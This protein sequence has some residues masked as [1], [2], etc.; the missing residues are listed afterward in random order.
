MQFRYLTVAVGDVTA[1][2]KVGLSIGAANRDPEVFG[3]NAGDLRLGRPNASS[4]LAF[5]SGPHACVG[6]ALVRIA[7]PVAIARFTGAA[8][9]VRLLE[10]NWPSRAGAAITGPQS[11]H[12]A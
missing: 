1:G 8:E 5:G 9:G 2:A 6:A 4:H 3:D 7:A 12:V 11:I 10:A